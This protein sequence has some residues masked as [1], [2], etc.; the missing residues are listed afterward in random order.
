MTW[1]SVAAGA[2]SGCLHRHSTRC[3]QTF[4]YQLCPPV[5]QV[6]MQAGVLG[7]SQQ[8]NGVR[9]L[10]LCLQQ[11]PQ[12]AEWRVPAAAESDEYMK[13]LP[14]GGP[15]I[16]SYLQ[17]CSPLCSRVGGLQGSRN[18]ALPD[19][20]PSCQ[21]HGLLC[22]ACVKLSRNTALEL[23][24]RLEKRPQDGHGCH[25]QSSTSSHSLSVRQ[26]GRGGAAPLF[27][28]GV[29]FNSQV[30]SCV[31]ALAPRPVTDRAASVILR[32]LLMSVAYFEP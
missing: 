30:S 29:K 12:R 21:L 7:A 18:S 4:C 26:Q 8:Q 3:R 5:V 32:C 27:T 2:A 13:L 19:A 25:A 1:V 20:W 24:Q 11:R 6:F 17:P 15:P 28:G 10:S 14:G 9:A 22:K 16:L 31:L 23:G